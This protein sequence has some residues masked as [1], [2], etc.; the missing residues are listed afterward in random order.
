MTAENVEEFV[1]VACA[2]FRKLCDNI[3]PTDL[4]RAKNSSLVALAT[5]REKPYSTACYMAGSYWQRGRVR[6]LDEMREQ[7]E[8]VTL[9][10]LRA[11]AAHVLSNTPSIALVGPVPEADYDELVRVAI[12]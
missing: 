11:A 10:D 1:A 5:L 6:S 12:S 7:I 8:A 2:E 9:D 4:E 3:N